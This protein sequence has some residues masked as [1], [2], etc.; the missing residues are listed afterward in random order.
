MGSQCGGP[1]PLFNFITSSPRPPSTAEYCSRSVQILVPSTSVKRPPRA[2]IKITANE[3]HRKTTMHTVWV[4]LN[5]VVFFGL[6]V[7]LG[8]SVLAA[9][10]KIGHARRHRPDIRVL[11]LNQMKSLKNHGGVDRALLSFDLHV[12]RWCCFP[13]FFGG[14]GVGGGDPRW[15]ASFA[16]NNM[17]APVSRRLS[18]YI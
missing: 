12:S 1:I 10:S 4:R 8:L 3:T 14:E 11:R 18:S 17:D 15:L 6:T 9:L 2:R 5:A 16:Y 13:R 7:L